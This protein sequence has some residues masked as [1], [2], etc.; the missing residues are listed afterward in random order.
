M[1]RKPPDGIKWRAS[2]ALMKCLDDVSAGSIRSWW[3]CNLFMAGG[4]PRKYQIENLINTRPEKWADFHNACIAEYKSWA[5]LEG[6][7]STDNSPN[8]RKPDR[9]LNGEYW[10]K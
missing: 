4:L 9:G 2:V 3:R 10:T 5:A 6:C 1:E 7:T 8:K